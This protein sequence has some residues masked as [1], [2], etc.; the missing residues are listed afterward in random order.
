[1]AMNKKNSF[2]YIVRKSEIVESYRVHLSDM[3]IM[4]T[5]PHLTEGTFHKDNPH[6]L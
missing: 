4:Y 5:A 6:C 1:M 3:L 2:I